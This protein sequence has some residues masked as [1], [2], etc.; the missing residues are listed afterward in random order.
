MYHIKKI[1]RFIIWDKNSS[2]KQFN[3][4]Y[5][6][7]QIDPISHHWAA[8]QFFFLHFPINSMKPG[9]IYE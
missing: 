8:T 5:T 1:E 7:F 2:L 4:I 3:Q 6:L 9:D